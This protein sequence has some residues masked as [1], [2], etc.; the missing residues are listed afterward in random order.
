MDPRFYT[1]IMLVIIGI[2][3]V[4]AGIVVIYID[5]IPL[6][7]RLPGDI[8][9]HGK[10]WSFHF[11]IITCLIISVILTIILNFFFRR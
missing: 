8:N 4:F 7:G 2:S 1:G 3:L 6:L 9:F 10:N 5:K 11:P